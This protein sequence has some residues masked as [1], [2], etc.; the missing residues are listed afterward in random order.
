MILI[1]VLAVLPPLVAFA[2]GL[3]STRRDEPTRVTERR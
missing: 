2:T 1:I 3:T